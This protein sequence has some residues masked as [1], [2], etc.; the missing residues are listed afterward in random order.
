MVWTAYS[1]RLERNGL[2]ADS[3]VS[4]TRHRIIIFLLAVAFAV[5]QVALA[6]YTLGVG[7]QTIQIPMLKHLMNPELY[8]QDALVT[9]SVAAYP[10]YAYVC[11]SFICQF[12]E[13]QVVYAVLHFISSCLLFGAV[14]YAS[15]V[16]FDE[17]QSGM[18]AACLLVLGQ[19]QALA[20][21]ELYSIGFTH[22]WLTLP[23]MLWSLVFFWQQRYLIAGI[24]LGLLFN[25]HALHAAYAALFMT[26]CF[27]SNY[28]RKQLKPFVLLVLAAVVLALP[29]LVQI[30]FTRQA[31]DAGWY[32]LMA[33][34]SAQH[35]FPLSLWQAGNS[36]ISDFAQIVLL[37]ACA[38]PFI[39]SPQHRRMAVA[40]TLLFV[41]LL[42]AGILANEHAII[43]KAQLWRSSALFLLLCLLLCGHGLWC[44]WQES[45][46][47]MRLC[48]VALSIC[49]I[50]AA[51]PSL[52]GLLYALLLLLSIAV[53]A[54]GVVSWRLAITL[55][56]CHCIIIS[57]GIFL[58]LPWLSI[59][60]GLHVYWDGWLLCCVLLS[61]LCIAAVVV[62]L[63]VPAMTGFVW[64][65]NL[66]VVV[67]A[68]AVLYLLIRMLQP[69]H[70]AWLEAQDWVRLNTAQDARIAV[71]IH[72]NG[73][74]I[75]SERAVAGTWRDGTQLYFLPGFA[76][77]WQKRMELLQPGLI[78]DLEQRQLRKP[79]RSLAHA[80][81]EE[82]LSLAEELGI[83]YL[84]LPQQRQTELKD[85]Y[86]NAAWQICLPAV[87]PPPPAPAYAKNKDVW[88][89]QQAFMRDVVEPNI[90]RYRKGDLRLQLFDSDG[91]PLRDYTYTL[92]LKQHDFGFASGLPFFK[93]HAQLKRRRFKPP[94]VK[95]V[96]LRHFKQV[97]N[98]STIPYSAKWM[99]LEPVEGHRFYDDLDAYVDWCSSNDIGMEFHFVTGYA[100]EWMKKKTAAEKQQALLRHT[101][102]LI[103][104]Y[105]DRIHHWQVVNE[106]K[107]LRE[108]VK[109]FALFRERLPGAK[110][111][112][113]DCARFY[114]K[115]DKDS[116]RYRHDLLR[117]MREVRWL[118]EQG[119]ELDYFAFHAH[120]PF[121]L[122]ADLRML[123]ETLD[124]FQAEGLRV[125]ISEFGMHENKKILGDVRG[126]TWNRDLQA[127]YYKLIYKACFSHPAVDVVNMW[128]ISSRTWMTGSGL[129]D[130][131]GNTK[132]AFHALH[133]LIHQELHSREAGTLPLH[134]RIEHRVFYGDYEL[135]VRL[136]DETELLI[137]VSFKREGCSQWRIQIDLRAGSWDLEAQPAEGIPGSTGKE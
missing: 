85:V 76:E 95:P 53:L 136:D 64:Q 67:L 18:T 134:G 122:W 80:S 52:Q 114:T 42:L 21:A 109:A 74:R 72:H 9:D 88:Q 92:T 131:E 89:A 106:K 26:A 135:R 93:E 127:D 96:D 87:E 123:Y 107:L 29:T 119:V 40:V 124:A 94:L 22:T 115:H 8:A 55:A 121:G 38:F 137:P 103:D 5:L 13:Y 86:R 17:L 58:S 104:R 27:L 36:S 63:T 59:G 3:D 125:H 130:S 23:W 28:D 113:S 46:M 82:L 120:R 34:R 48:A 132:P 45:G 6:G 49:V 54:A 128:G 126:G 56:V 110:L 44:A 97:F 51:V 108:S 90:E 41:L 105:G 75:N 16:L 99:Y 69:Q 1:E 77:T 47:T 11:L 4:V 70:N 43:I 15:W 19:H 10:S 78:F 33:V 35:S 68:G 31:P 25:L 101:R 65:A 112:I 39:A 79:G 32:A 111:G 24:S 2:L 61:L 50:A 129:V 71:P 117:G 7:N 118:R 66:S 60:G 81:D 73:F 12:V 133:G 14:L 91:K 100:P 57:A 37:S 102:Q 62:R 98:F 20:G 116:S 84:V 83:D 30:V